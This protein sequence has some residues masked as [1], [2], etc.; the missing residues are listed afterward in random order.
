MSLWNVQATLRADANDLTRGGGERRAGSK[1]A[2]ERARPASAPLRRNVHDAQHRSPAALRA[3]ELSR[4]SSDVKAERKHFG[5]LHATR[6][7]ATRCDRF[8]KAGRAPGAR[9]RG[10]LFVTRI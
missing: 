9:M 10:P 4:S 7:A 1:D 6:P 5:G 2:V 3:G 8:R